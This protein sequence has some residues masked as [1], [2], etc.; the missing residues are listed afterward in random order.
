MET[1]GVAGAEVWDALM[2]AAIAGEAQLR[3]RLQ[4]R[5]VSARRCRRR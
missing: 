5:L 3:T 2:D 1:D 4:L